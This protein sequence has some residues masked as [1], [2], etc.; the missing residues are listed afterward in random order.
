M[1]KLELM[2]K[3]SKLLRDESNTIYTKSFI[4][5]QINESIDRIK[6]LIPELRGMVYLLVDT[7][8]PILIP[9]E[10]QHLMS[11]YA[12]ARCY[13][14]DERHYEANKYMN[15]FEIKINN[16][17]DSIA[18]GELVIT[19]PNTGLPVVNDVN[20]DYVRNVYFADSEYVS[21]AETI[22]VM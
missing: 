12:C 18:S 6:Q 3:S 15:E 22:P 8:M 20:Q 2:I 21:D 7:D 16:I 4:S 14:V 13:E 11:I 1:T 17:K 9:V 10:Y 19:D 5:D